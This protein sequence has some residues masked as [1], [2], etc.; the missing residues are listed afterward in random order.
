MLRAIVGCAI[1]AYACAGHSKEVTTPIDPF[2]FQYE[3]QTEIRANPLTPGADRVQGDVDA[4]PF[5]LL[6]QKRFE[7]G[8]S[9][10]GVLW[11]NFATG[12]WS[13]RNQSPGA[14]PKTAMKGYEYVSLA[15][16]RGFTP[17][18][19][20]QSWFYQL[21][22]GTERDTNKHVQL[23]AKAAAQG[24]IHAR[25]IKAIGFRLQDNF[26]ELRTLASEGDPAGLL[27]L[28]REYQFG[29]LSGTEDQLTQLQR[30][31][32]ECWR[33]HRFSDCGYYHAV[34]EVAER[35]FSEAAKAID[36]IKAVAPWSD[37]ASSSGL[38]LRTLYLQGVV[39]G[40]LATGDQISSAQ[41]ELGL[42]FG[43]EIEGATQL[44]AP[45][46]AMSIELALTHLHYSDLQ[47]KAPHWLHSDV[48]RQ[49]AAD[50]LDFLRPFSEAIA[51]HSKRAAAIS[52]END[53][54][55]WRAQ[56]SLLSAIVTLSSGAFDSYDPRLARDYAQRLLDIDP[57]DPDARAF[58]GWLSEDISAA[59]ALEICSYSCD[60]FQM[61]HQ[62]EVQYQ[63]ALLAEIEREK[64]EKQQQANR[65][66]AIQ[67]SQRIAAQQSN[68]TQARSSGGG[69][70]SFLGDVLAIAAVVG[71]VVL[72]V[73]YAP[74]ALGTLGGM[75][76]M[77]SPSSYAIQQPTVQSAQQ[78]K[79]TTGFTPLPNTCISDYSCGAGMMC[80]KQAYS[81]GGICVTAVN[82]F[83]I[84]TYPQP[85]PDSVNF[86]GTLQGCKF[87]SDCPVGFSCN[88][89]YEVCV[90]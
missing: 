86:Q 89:D 37:P 19:H 36:E 5:M 81:S 31:Y 53:I 71:I 52:I 11:A 46:D 60:Y 54:V 24:D 58:L 17:A 21:G 61:M 90:R 6:L 51:K 88:R 57:E 67:Q 62:L 64:K 39:V 35:E 34:G 44:I 42:R 87:P 69:F 43:E 38:A 9:S 80:I 48:P 65:A 22:I 20:Y 8:D 15:A 56:V 49:Y 84:K 68:S 32:S 1:F 63:N 14:D 2:D 59:A 40:M 78:R 18:I 10:A 55:D 85:R 12:F 26:S 33:L 25:R 3:F 29:E 73:N 41:I 50:E 74:A 70:F 23:L 16:E 79:Q 47:Q 76:P 75:A 13:F 30:L 82:Q 72:A 45:E 77:D 7:S 66:A 83:G 27:F 28:A 4:D